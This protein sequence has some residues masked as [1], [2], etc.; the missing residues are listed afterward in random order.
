M[1]VGAIRVV[2]EGSGT[3]IGVRAALLRQLILGVAALPTLGLGVATLAWTAV[4]DP[5]VAAS[6]LARP[7]RRTRSWSTYGPCPRRSPR[8]DAG[9]R[10]V[11]NL[12]ALRLVPA[13]R[14]RRRAPRSA[15]AARRTPH[16]RPAA[17]RPS[18]R[19]SRPGTPAPR[20]GTPLR[21]AP[22]PAPR[23]QLGYPLRARAAPGRRRRR[24]LPRGGATPRESC[25]R[26]GGSA[27]TRGS[28]SSSRGSRWSDVDR[29]P[30]NGERVRHL[31]RAAVRR[32]CRCRRPT[33]SSRSPPTV[34][35]W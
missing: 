34:R 10:H 20:P 35:W 2:R 3:P 6:R 11:V 23:Q 19:T 32:T 27:S 26:G 15:P 22:P 1:A 8:P 25:R 21:A 18:G 5:A 12:T 28:R 16:R 24:R 29:R 30:R 17:R 4:M 31:V 14:P 13:P 7:R 33:R 9:P